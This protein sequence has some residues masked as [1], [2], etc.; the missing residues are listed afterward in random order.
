[1]IAAIR[2]QPAVSVASLDSH[3][4]P[5]TNERGRNRLCSGRSQGEGLADCVLMTGVPSHRTS[6]AVGSLLPSR[7]APRRTGAYDSVALAEGLVRPYQAMIEW[8]YR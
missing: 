3:G 2:S 6:S 8:L 1:M 5:R 7:S 4:G